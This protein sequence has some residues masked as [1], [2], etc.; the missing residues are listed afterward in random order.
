MRRNGLFKVA[1]PAILV[2]S[3]LFLAN[4]TEVKDFLTKLNKEVCSDIIKFDYKPSA[5]SRYNITLYIKY[6]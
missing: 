3:T 6:Y 4:C 5:Y 1:F 2:M